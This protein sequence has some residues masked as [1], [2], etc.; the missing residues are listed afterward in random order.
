MNGKT[1]RSRDCGS[2]ACDQGEGLPTPALRCSLAGPLRA[3]H[4]EVVDRQDATRVGCLC[5]KWCGAERVALCSAGNCHLVALPFNLQHAGRYIGCQRIAAISA[6]RAF[7]P[8][9]GLQQRCPRLGA[10]ASQNQALVAGPSEADQHCYAGEGDEQLDEGEA[11]V[12]MCV[13]H[14]RSVVQHMPALP[15]AG[16]GCG[17]VAH[18]NGLQ[19]SGAA[20]H[21]TF[22]Q[23]GDAIN[24]RRSG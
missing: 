9:R 14:E 24:K 12:W 10:L 13:F 11:T 16:V 19:H 7:K 4:T 5:T 1:C 2:F 18:P 15:L 22:G 3:A 8:V 17:C 20:R 23:C 6:G 21:D